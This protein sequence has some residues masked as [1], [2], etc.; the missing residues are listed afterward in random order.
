M[1]D[2][3]SPQNIVLTGFGRI[4]F[5]RIS[6]RR[7]LLLVLVCGW[8]AACSSD[9]PA[10]LEQRERV[11][12][13]TWADAPI[14]APIA[15]PADGRRCDGVAGNSDIVSQFAMPPWH[16]GVFQKPAFSHDK[17]DPIKSSA[18]F[19]TDFLLT[20]SFNRTRTVERQYFEASARHDL[21]Y[22]HGV[23]T[24]GR[25]R[26][27][28]DSRIFAD[29]YRLCGLADNTTLEGRSSCHY[30]PPAVYGA[31]W[32]FG[33]VFSAV[34]GSAETR[35]ICEYESGGFQ[36]ARDHLVIGH[37]IGAKESEQI[38]ELASATVP[39][40]KCKGGFLLRGTVIDAVHKPDVVLNLCPS[41][42]DLA[43][44]GKDKPQTLGDLEITVADLLSHAPVRI[45]LDNPEQKQDDIVLF[46]FHGADKNGAGAGKG[47]GALMIPISIENPDKT[48]AFQ[49]PRCGGGDNRGS[50]CWVPLELEKKSADKVVNELALQREAFSYPVRPAHVM[51]NCASGVHHRCSD[52]EQ[53]L[54]TSTA[55]SGENSAMVIATYAF[56]ASADGFDL[57]GV[58]RE[59][60]SELESYKRL[61]YPS[62]TFNDDGKDGDDIHFLFRSPRDLQ[63]TDL[64]VETLHPQSRPECPLGISWGKAVKRENVCE[65]LSSLPPD[66]M[67]TT[68]KGWSRESYIW[69][70]LGVS[71][72]S[73]ASLSS[74]TEL[75]AEFLS[76][77]TDAAGKDCKGDETIRLRTLALTRMTTG[78]PPISEYKLGRPTH[79]E[80]KKKPPGCNNSVREYMKLPVLTGRFGS[81]RDNGLGLAFFCAD[82]DTLRILQVWRPKAGDHWRTQEYSCA[83]GDKEDAWKKLSKFPLEVIA[84]AGNRPSSIILSERNGESI[85]YRRFATTERTGADI[86]C[87]L[88]NLPGWEI[89]QFY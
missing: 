71:Q 19:A 25:A 12:R 32:L 35:T 38:L 88:Q 18:G 42:I 68:V 24:Y 69:M 20:G 41:K 39:D 89:K 86:S 87:T 10:D 49:A 78:K 26:G 36:P 56:R 59:P 82:K 84:N 55:K 60:I 47:F 7:L 40:A 75:V 16:N 45:R 21:C 28:C 51:P 62:L 81:A 58:D 23:L 85:Q 46:A 50:S 67:Q 17:L 72:S 33:G 2:M 65:T 61:Q 31:V 64:V 74:D 34:S 66:S 1:F 22:Q 53:L 43:Y 5:M 79:E 13:Q 29:M 3:V 11:R 48:R 76:N 27:D 9:S 15:A 57:I 37:F 4:L 44:A 14:D 80:D 63:L 77:C 8:V 52:G 6:D 70:P 54:L 30:R 73:P 83:L